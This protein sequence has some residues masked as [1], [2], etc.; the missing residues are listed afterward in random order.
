MNEEIAALIALHA[1]LDRQGPGDP[2]F[3]RRILAGLPTLLESPRI[4]DLGCG[5]GAGSLLLAEW[6]GVSVTAVDL[7]RIFLDQ[8]EQRAKEAGLAHLIQTLEADMGQLDWPDASIDF[9][10]SE[11]A[12]YHL[13]FPG[14]L[15]NWHRLLSHGGFAI[16]SELSWF[17]ENPAVPVREFWATAYPTMAIEAENADQAREAGYDVIAT[18][19]L[20][21]EAW[22]THYYGPL[23]DRMK[24]QRA[25]A[26]RVMAQVIR[27]TDVEMDLF[28]NYSSDYGYTFYVLRKR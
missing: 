24:S 16:I 7:S 17:T 19:R 6:F 12:A 20:P 10:W 11:G 28:R 14:A 25:E 9:L 18:E 22:W 23:R 5:S 3:S 1:G 27:D 4:A 15:R 21:A 13:T 2:E 26:D 8:L